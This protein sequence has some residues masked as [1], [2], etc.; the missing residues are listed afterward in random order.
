MKAIILL[1]GGLDSSLLLAMAVQQKKECLALSFD[2]NQRHRI[3][4]SYAKKIA[5]YYGVE[6]KILQI[7]ANSF[8]NSSLID[9]K[10][11]SKN[12][13]KDQI[14]ASSPSTY[15]PAR[16]TL[17]LAYGIVFAEIYG[18]NEIHFG[19]TATD[20]DSYI[21]CRPEFIN[22]MQGVANLATNQAILGKAP[23][24]VTPLIQM[25]KEEIVQ[26]AVSV[27]LPLELTWSCYDPQTEQPCL[28]CDACV[29]RK[30][31]LGNISNL[32]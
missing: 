26:K 21:D 24:I 6:H 8:Q 16:N 9:R 17:F 14:F 25:T 3:E 31:A 10:D 22:A 7:D 23:L 30:M 13:T 19:P 11:I 4:L 20:F 12:R 32:D 2:Y 1:S 18:A 28:E 29:L 5:H 15:V 27:K